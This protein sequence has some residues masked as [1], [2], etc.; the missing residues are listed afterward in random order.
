MLWQTRSR[1]T[2]HLH[3]LAIAQHIIHVRMLHKLRQWHDKAVVIRV[4]WL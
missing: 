4:Y 1:Y 3:G 2:I